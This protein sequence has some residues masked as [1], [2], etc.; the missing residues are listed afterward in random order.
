MRT[1]LQTGYK[2]VFSENLQNHHQVN[3]IGE[4]WK[5]DFENVSSGN[6][7]NNL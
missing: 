7:L 6:E 3:E 1:T 5:S 4:A 2:G